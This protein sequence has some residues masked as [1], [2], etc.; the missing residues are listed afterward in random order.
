MD[1]YELVQ[2]F[3][4]LHL[5]LK[6]QARAVQDLKIEAKC[7]SVK[8]RKIKPNRTRKEKH[9]LWSWCSCEDCWRNALAW[10]SGG[11][12][13]GSAGVPAPWRPAPR[14]DSLRAVS[15]LP[16]NLS[17]I[18]EYMSALLRRNS[19]L[20]S[21]KKIQDPDVAIETQ[22]DEFIWNVLIPMRYGFCSS[23]SFVRCLHTD[24]YDAPVSGAKLYPSTALIQG[25]VLK[26]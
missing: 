21:R 5:V 25:D 6:F 11:T 15:Q 2:I 18:F 14:T 26:R 24:T 3:C 1:L 7:E 10:P 4:L 13:G 22:Y 20:R 17:D 12:S 16:S 19:S 9:P 23:R 8:Y